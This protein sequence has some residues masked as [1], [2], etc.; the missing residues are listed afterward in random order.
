[1]SRK[2]EILIVKRMSSVQPSYDDYLRIFREEIDEHLHWQEAQEFY[3][4]LTLESGWKS[5]PRIIC[6]E[7]AKIADKIPSPR[8]KKALGDFYSLYAY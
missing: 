2:C 1:M 3:G 4:L 6:D 5:P 8:F 7:L